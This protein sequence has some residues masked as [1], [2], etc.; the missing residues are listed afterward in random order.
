MSEMEQLC[1][2]NPDR[3]QHSGPDC[4]AHSTSSPRPLLFPSPGLSLHPDPGLQLASVLL[5]LAR[6]PHP[7]LAVLRAR[8]A[9]ALGIKGQYLPCSKEA[10]RQLEEEQVTYF[11][12]WLG[13]KKKPRKIQNLEI[14]A[15]RPVTPPRPGWLTRCNV[16][17][18]GR[19]AP[20]A[21]LASSASAAMQRGRGL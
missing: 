9:D 16:P 20:Q 10:Q 17:G 19:G 18:S 12:G 8:K 1:V 15:E 4:W 21:G 13:K 2:L 6:R 14:D 11:A 7:P 5:R 3:V